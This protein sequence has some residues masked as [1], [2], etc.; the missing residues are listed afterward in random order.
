MTSEED[1]SLLEEANARLVVED[2]M[3]R[4]RR[5]E[6]IMVVLLTVFVRKILSRVGGEHVLEK[7]EMISLWTS[8]VHYL[9]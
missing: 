5:R 1:S 6:F 4:R 9:Q 2:V 7:N 8:L 3:V